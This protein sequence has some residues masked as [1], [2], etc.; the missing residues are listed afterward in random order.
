MKKIVL[1]IIS[2]IFITAC[3]S[4]NKADNSQSKV[5]SDYITKNNLESVNKVRTFK[6]QNWKP[7]DNKHVILSSF[8]KRQYLITFKNYCNDLPFTQTIV[9]NQSMNNSLSAKFDSIIINT[10]PVNQTCYIDSIHELNQD[11][12]KE[13]LALRKKNN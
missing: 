8:H 4:T 2:L 6:M 5:Y 13:V 11:Q 3:A 12:E 10:N 9:L 7:L 1:T